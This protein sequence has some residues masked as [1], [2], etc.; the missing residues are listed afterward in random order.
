M[1]RRTPPWAL[2]DG[3]TLWCL[4]RTVRSAGTAD[5]VGVPAGARCGPLSRPRDV[6][7]QR[8]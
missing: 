7:V 8:R 6:T 4:L 1:H 2:V 5:V 3:E